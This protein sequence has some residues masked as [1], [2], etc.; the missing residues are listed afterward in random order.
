MQS[1]ISLLQTL[2]HVASRDHS[3]EIKD[4]LHCTLNVIQTRLRI[5]LINSG[6]KRICGIDATEVNFSN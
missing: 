2:N 1:T 5:K 4:I 6:L 3:K